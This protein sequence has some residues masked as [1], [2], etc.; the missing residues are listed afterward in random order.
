MYFFQNVYHF[1]EKIFLFQTINIYLYII[2][3]AEML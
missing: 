1:I 2:E 3:Q